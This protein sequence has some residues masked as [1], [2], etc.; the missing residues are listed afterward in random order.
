MVTEQLNLRGQVLKQFQYFNL[1]SVTSLRVDQQGLTGLADDTYHELAA[2]IGF[3]K[4][5]VVWGWKADG[6]LEDR[7]VGRTT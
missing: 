4:T 7:P 2:F 5:E 6:P 1:V 3:M